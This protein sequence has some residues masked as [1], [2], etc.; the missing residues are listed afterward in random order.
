VPASVQTELEERI[1]LWIKRNKKEDSRLEFKRGIDLRTVDAKAEFVRDVIA[2]ANSQGECPRQQGLL[3]IG[4]KDGRYYDIQNEHHDGAT[5]GQILDS[6]VYPSVDVLYEEFGNRTRKRFGVLIVKPDTNLLYIVKKKLLG[7]KGQLLLVPGQSWGRRSDRKVALDGDEIHARWQQ[8]L[9]RITE[10][11]TEPL[12]ARI[13]KL[14]SESGPAFEV[15]R[16]RFE[17]EA[18]TGWESLEGF[19]E[20]LSPYAREFDYSVKHEVLTA[21][22]EV[23]GRTR[24][25]MTVPVARAVD[26]LLTEIMPMGDG[27]IFYPSRTEIT[28][29]DQ[30]LLSRIEQYT[31]EITWD[32]C[33]YLH[34]LK[35]VEIG[36]H[37]YW[38]L[39]RVATLNRLQHFQSHCVSRARHC[40]HICMEGRSG[41]VFQEGYDRLEQEISDALDVSDSDRSSM[42]S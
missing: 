9:G 19:L 1:R 41:N 29:D 35:L 3:V 10:G 21:I 23:T 27:G 37:L 42:H 6:Y 2:L 14:Q 24:H 36:A 20:K 39:I 4:S 15:K 33:R 34:D 12:Q 22:R 13:E 30:K 5:F 8:I 11:V 32:A 38:T 26:S 40:Q 28:R 7:D 25:G 31:F 17:M 16:I 18:N